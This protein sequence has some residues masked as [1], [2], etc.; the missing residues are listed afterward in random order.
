M[1]LQRVLCSSDSMSGPWRTF[2]YREVFGRSRNA[3]GAELSAA[4]RCELPA[5]ACDVT[6]MR[7][8]DRRGGI[9]KRP[10]RAGPGGPNASCNLWAWPMTPPGASM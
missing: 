2:H 1:L 10:D 6:A 3:C 5:C 7:R 8:R 9:T 4:V